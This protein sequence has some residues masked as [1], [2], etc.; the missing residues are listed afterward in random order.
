M[1][2]KIWHFA[3]D[4]KISFALLMSATLI[5]FT[6]SMY[7]NSDFALIRALN[8]TRV[9]DWML[10]NIAAN[11]SVIWWVPVLFIV[12]GCLGLNTFICATNRVI[13]LISR[14]NSFSK[15]RFF[16]LLTP[17]IIHYLFIFIMLGHF[18]TF[19]TGKWEITPLE[20]GVH[21]N[22]GQ[23]GT[24]FTVT[25]IRDS[26]FADTSEMR[27]RIYQT[28]VTLTDNKNK[29][30]IIQ[31]LSPVIINGHFLFLDKIKKKQIAQKIIDPVEGKIKETCNQAH[32]Y[33][34]KTKK[35]IGLRLL[36]I[37]DPGLCMII[38]GLSV[39]MMLMAWYF[40]FQN[41][42]KDVNY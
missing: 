6:G 12:M 32:V 4:I 33:H 25:S 7:G 23:E 41:T 21:V 17:T 16:Y 18:I 3:G 19:T 24:P 15:T 14:R 40:I 11:L 22:I 31:Y 10:E 35:H 36:V 38:V 8:R 28:R 9:Q 20:E 37:S 29:E 13:E 5:L 42:G 2:K 1:L 26:F 30:I 39:I 27:D 34:E